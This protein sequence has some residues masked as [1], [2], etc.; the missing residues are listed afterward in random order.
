[1]VE[2]GRFN[3]WHF[4]LKRLLRFLL[5]LVLRIE[6]RGMGKIPREGPVIVYFNHTDVVDPLVVAGIIGREVTIMGKEE[7]FGIPVVGPVLRAYGVFPVRRQEGDARAVKRA[8]SILRQDG[9]LVIAPEGTRNRD[10]VLR[11]AK[12]GLIHLALRT[13]AL[14]QPMAVLGSRP[15]LPN[16][17][18]LRRTSIRVTVG[19]PYRLRAQSGGKPTREEIEDMTEEAMHRLAAL[20]PPELR[21]V[22]GDGA[23]C[24]ADRFAAS[25]AAGA[26]RRGNT[27]LG[28]EPA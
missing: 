24:E 1:M 20:M 6:C 3:R 15:F 5:G 9:L 19:D 7:L 14:V 16:L 25:R 2:R 4:A 23:D 22:Y 28:G 13:G 12:P 21:G 17:R 10:G 8:L 18:R 27:S 11:R 26:P